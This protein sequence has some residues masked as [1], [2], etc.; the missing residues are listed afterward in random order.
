MASGLLEDV[1]CWR[2]SLAPRRPSSPLSAAARTTLASSTAILT[3]PFALALVAQQMGLVDAWP[4]EAILAPIA[5]ALLLRRP[6]E[7]HPA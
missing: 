4:T 5:V 2:T 6:S 1:V 3:A 7:M